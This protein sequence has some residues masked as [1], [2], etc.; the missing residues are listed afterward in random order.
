MFV[1]V[2][3]GISNTCMYPSFAFKRLKAA[4]TDGIDTVV[5]V[6]K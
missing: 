4:P 5:A 2:W 3:F 6:V 1:S